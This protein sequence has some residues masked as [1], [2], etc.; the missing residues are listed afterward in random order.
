MATTQPAARRVRVQDL[1]YQV[2][3][4]DRVPPVATGTQRTEP[5]PGGRP[6]VYP[7]MATS[8][9]RAIRM[10][11]V[12]IIAALAIAVAWVSVSGLGLV[13]TGVILVAI[14]GFLS[15]GSSN[16]Q[17]HQRDGATAYR[18][19]SPEAVGATYQE[20]AAEN[21][22]LRERL[23]QA[24]AGS[25]MLE[26][27]VADLEE[28]NAELEELNEGLQRQVQ[29]LEATLDS[30][31]GHL[32]AARRGVVQHHSARSADREGVRS[33]SPLAGALRRTSVG[34]DA[35]R[36]ALA[37]SGRGLAQALRRCHAQSAD[38]LHVALRAIGRGLL[39]TIALLQACQAAAK[40]RVRRLAL[41]IVERTQ[42]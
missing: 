33:G 14:L 29:D 35:A 27:Q 31:M 20:L 40:R 15:A 25:A 41:A 17:A 19:L 11:A 32:E 9:R 37:R 21:L 6:N 10:V 36:L 1:D 39:A 3:A 7:R 16:A 22:W 23:Q 42:A 8:R 5:A 12:G 24:T 28:L 26:R 30:V 34:H 13:L 4:G 18:E 38:F 2:R